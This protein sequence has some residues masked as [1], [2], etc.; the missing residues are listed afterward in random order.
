[1]KDVVDL[2]GRILLSFI[3]IYEAIDSILYF[4][5]TTNLMTEY[6]ITFQQDLLLIGGVFLLLAGGTL[7]LIGYRI[8][9]GAML[10][11]IYWI[12]VTFIV[13]SFWNDALPARRL[14][15]ILFMK[16]IAILGGLM[17]M[18][19]NTSGK[20]SIKTLLANTRVPKRFR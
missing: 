18:A 1:M 2:L 4:K 13:H 16:N 8:G 9:L 5:K 20:Y 10:L 19:V 14:E 15:S 6:G 3:F 12:P 17:F 11:M 7:L